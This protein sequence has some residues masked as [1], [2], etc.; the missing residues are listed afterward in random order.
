MQRED[1]QSAILVRGLCGVPLG[2]RACEKPWGR[3]DIRTEEWRIKREQRA[4]LAEDAL[5]CVAVRGLC[6]V[7]PRDGGRRWDEPR[8]RCPNHAEEK[9]RCENALD[10]NPRQRCRNRRVRNRRFCNQHADYPNFSVT[11]QQ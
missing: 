4:M 6:G 10:R 1:E 11:A 8:G 9:E 7:V 5:S 3:C 2:N